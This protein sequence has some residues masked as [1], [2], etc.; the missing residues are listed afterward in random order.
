MDAL[1]EAVR[2]GNSNSRKGVTFNDDNDNNM[3]IRELTDRMEAL[4]TA[5]EV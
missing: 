4:E 3:L 1:E 2:S 5:I